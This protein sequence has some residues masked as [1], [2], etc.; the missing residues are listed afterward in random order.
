MEGTNLTLKD[1]LGPPPDMPWREFADW[2]KKDDENTVWGWIRNGGMD[3]M[4]KD[5]TLNL[6]SVKTFAVG[7]C[8]A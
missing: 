4:K 5:V 8:H 2:I 1:L 6:C 3:A 7:G